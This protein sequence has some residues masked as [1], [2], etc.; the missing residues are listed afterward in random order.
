MPTAA[1]PQSICTSQE[2]SSAARCGAE[3]SG[4]SWRGL[5]DGEQELLL[6]A[7]LELL[8]RPG[9]TTYRGAV[10]FLFVARKDLAYGSAGQSNLR[11]MRKRISGLSKEDVHS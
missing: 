3:R 9:P 2:S 10:G 4:K 7:Q 5:P 8:P 6:Q 11:S 1:L